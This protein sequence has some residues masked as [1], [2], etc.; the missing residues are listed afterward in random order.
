MKTTLTALL[1]LACASVASA[2]DLTLSFAGTP[3]E[4][5]DFTGTIQKMT[6]AYTDGVSVTLSVT[7]D[8]YLVDLGGGLIASSDGSPFT[9]VF[10]GLE[11]GAAYNI[12]LDLGDGATIAG[13]DTV[14]DEAGVIEFS[15]STKPM[16]TIKGGKIVSVN[17][18]PEPATATLSLL[19]LAG[20]AARRRR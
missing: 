19:A 7:G 9:L 18:I 5:P 8:A 16:T 4:E 12:T 20:L 6:A 13:V 3:L 11:A 17:A 15:Y 1:A 14:A 2:L 10:E